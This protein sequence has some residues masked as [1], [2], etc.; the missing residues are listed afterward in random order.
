M[1]QVGITGG[2]GSGKSTVASIFRMLGI[3][4]YDAD[5]RAKALM[6]SDPALK[7]AIQQHFGEATYDE[8]GKLQRAELASKVFGDAEQLKLLESLVHPAVSQDGIRWHK[9]QREVPYTLKEAALLYESGSFLGLD[10]TIVVTAPVEL[11]IQR[12]VARDQTTREAVLQRMDKQWPEEKKVRR[13]NFVVYNDGQRSLIK[14][15]LSIHRALC[16]LSDR[17]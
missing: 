4:V 1:L 5:S 6:E 8:A 17:K 7:Q 14:Q 12:V 9:S 2:I 3:P 16:A 13:S 15:V 10:Y 11:R